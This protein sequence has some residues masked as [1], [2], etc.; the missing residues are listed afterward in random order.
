MS[1]PAMSNVSVSPSRL[2]YLDLVREVEDLFYT[3]ADLLDGRR[4][5]EWLDLFTDDVHYWMPMR[6][7]VPWRDQSGD[8]SSERRGR[9]V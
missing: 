3:E 5:E 8:T 7:N 1:G 2:L 6:R 4:Y 9:L